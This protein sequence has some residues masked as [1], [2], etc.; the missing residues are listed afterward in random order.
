MN[1]IK[2]ERLL[3]I[4]VIKLFL[5]ILKCFIEDDA[6]KFYII[7]EGAVIIFVPKDHCEL[8]KDLKLQRV[9]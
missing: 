9:K 7:L 4:I 1:S 3:C 5:K 6:D 2:R 8:K